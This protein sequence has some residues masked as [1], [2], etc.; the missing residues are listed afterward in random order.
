[1]A[2]KPLPVL[3]YTVPILPRRAVAVHKNHCYDSQ[4]KHQLNCMLCSFKE[5][6]LQYILVQKQVVQKVDKS[7]TY[8]T[9]SPA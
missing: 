7:Y 9:S 4:S 3:R 8:I 1:V 2:G 5:Y 6:A